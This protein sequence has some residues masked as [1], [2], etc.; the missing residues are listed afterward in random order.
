MNTTVDKHAPS[1]PHLPTIDVVT[2]LF[3]PLQRGKHAQ[4][5][6]LTFSGISF[7]GRTRR[8]R[9]RRHSRDVR[10][11]R[12]PW[13]TWSPW[14][15]R[16]TR[17]QGQC[18][19]QYMTL[20]QKKPYSLGEMARKNCTARAMI[21]TTLQELML[22]EFQWT[23]QGT[24]FESSGVLAG[25]VFGNLHC[26]KEICAAQV[27]SKHWHGLNGWNWALLWTRSRKKRLS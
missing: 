10:K 7:T 21:H 19:A 9:G 5:N 18:S 12:E 26:W 15:T 20:S 14:S 25:A 16:T 13:C 6:R 17:I 4:V 1:Q 3:L 24:S 11:K 8:W 23:W 2:L 27:F 22:L